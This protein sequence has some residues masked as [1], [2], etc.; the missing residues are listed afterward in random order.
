MSLLPRWAGF[1]EVT[2][3]EEESTELRMEIRR[4][5]GA[6]LPGG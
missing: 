5:S 1:T 2:E 3:E 4:S 6:E